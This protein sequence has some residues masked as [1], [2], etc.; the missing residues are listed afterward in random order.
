M[1]HI[2]NQDPAPIL[3]GISDPLLRPWH[4]VAVTDDL[5]ARVAAALAAYIGHPVPWTGDELRLVALNLMKSIYILTTNE[6]Q[7]R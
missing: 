2:S 6:D 5:V 3:N 7:G 4:S 1:S